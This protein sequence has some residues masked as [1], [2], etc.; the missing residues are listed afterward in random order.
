MS[1]WRTVGFVNQY[2]QI[3]NPNVHK[4]FAMET[5]TEKRNWKSEM[6]SISYDVWSSS[7]FCLDSIFFIRY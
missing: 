4:A 2:N 7:S 5:V 3:L 6:K 1:Q